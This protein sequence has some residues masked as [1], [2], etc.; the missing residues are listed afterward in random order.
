MFDFA[1]MKTQLIIVGILVS[2]IVVLG[3][4]AK[5]YYDSNLK[6]ESKI[7]EIEQANKNLRETIT[8]MEKSKGIDNDI[9]ANQRKA[10]DALI[11]NS[12]GIRSS[13]VAAVDKIISKY[14]QLPQTPEN[15]K[16]RDAEVSNRRILDL[17]KSYCITRPDHNVCKQL[18]LDGGDK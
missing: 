13:T 3:L 4:I 10:I 8:F 9:I 18:M 12:E 5:H 16:L 7:I 2:V 17:W 1:K 11:T 15:T 14:Q 6:N